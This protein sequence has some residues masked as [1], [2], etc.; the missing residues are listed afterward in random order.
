MH[1]YCRTYAWTHGGSSDLWIDGHVFH[2]MQAYVPD[3]P[4]DMHSFNSRPAW[5]ANMQCIL[6]CHLARL[7]STNLQYT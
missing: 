2:C 3:Y 5:H 7:A 4:E 1:A 6:L